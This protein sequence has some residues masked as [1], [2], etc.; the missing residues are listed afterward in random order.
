MDSEQASKWISA[1]RFAPF[2]EAA[3]GDRE[4]ALALYEWHGALAATCFGAMHHFEVLV[5]NAI[6]GELGRED[7]ES[8]MTETWLL[9]FEILRVDGVKQVIVAA[10][11]LGKEH[12]ITRSRIVAGLPFGFWSGLFGG[13][14]EDL[15]R[16]RLRHAFPHAKERKDL[17]VPMEALRRFRN[18]LAHHDSILQQGVRERHGDMLRVAGFVDPAARTWIESSSGVA[19]LLAQRPGKG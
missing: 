15:W 5:R 9:D 11:R 7:P 6:D 4:Q 12:A 17:S 13:R 10:E 19:E 18:R 1:T 14:Y 16:R 2:M 3:G 8:P